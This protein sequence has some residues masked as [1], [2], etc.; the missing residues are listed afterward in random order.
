VLRYAWR[1]PQGLPPTLTVEWQLVSARWLAIVIVLLELLWLQ[2]SDREHTSALLIVGVGALYNLAVQQAVHRRSGLLAFGYVTA[3]GDTL[4]I[5]AMVELAGGFDSPFAS[6]FFV[7]CVSIAMRCGFGPALSMALLVIAAESIGRGA[8]PAPLA[9]RGVCLCLS[10]FFASHVR[11]Q[12]QRETMQNT[13]ILEQMTEAVL[14]TDAAGRIVLTNAAAQKLY[15]SPGKPLLGTSMAAPLVDVLG[16]RKLGVDLYE[17]AVRRALRG[18]PMEAEHQVFDASGNGQWLSASATPLRGIRGSIQGA[19]VVAHDLTERKL[20]L[21]ALRASEER[22]RNQYKGFP[23]PTYSWIRDGDDFFLQDFNDAAKAIDEA[24]V[25]EMLI[26]RASERYA[27]QPEILADLQECVAEQRTL[28][29]EMRYRFRRTGLERNV[30]VTYVFVPPQTVMAHIEDVTEA[31]Q[32]EQQREAMAQSEKLRAL[33]QMASGIAHDLNQSLMLVASYSDLARQALVQDPPNVAELE[34]LLTTTTQAALDGGETVK[35]LLQFTQAVPEHEG[36][37]VDLSSV[38]RDAAQLTAP[39][40]RDAAQAEGRPISLHVEVEGNPTIQGSPAR[41]RELMTNLIFNAVDALPT[42]GAIR[43]RVTA[44]DGQGIVEV[45]DSGIGMSAAVQERVFEPF[46]T[47][48]GEGGTGLGLA[49]VFGIVER[50]RGHIEVHSAPDDGT[51]F[52]M[53]FPLMADALAEALLTPSPRPSVQLEPP[54]PLRVLA[55]DDEPMMT[56]AVVRMLK[57]SGHL[58]SVAGS[59][60][61]A[62][63]KLAEQTFDVVVSDMGMGAGMNGWELAEAVR[64]RWPGVRFLLA[65]G[66]GAG[67]DPVEAR[68]KGIEA[69]LA[70]PYHP[71][72]LLEALGRT[73]VAA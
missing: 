27:G 60:E 26:V 67:M 70:K 72:E 7:L 25:G 10:V 56:K 39:R 4:L 69:V 58:V 38:V 5:L 20:V 53:T 37:L 48:K 30:V 57:P 2:L 43:L 11:G 41:L 31:K 18:E 33:G 29:R 19:I 52:R 44:E 68:T 45:I 14:V 3:L 62:L 23:L 49:M 61:E 35:R 65:T 73:D 64:S 15:G 21:E 13:A 50:H 40:W 32:A 22:F 6:V 8:A 59:G 24:D 36:K 34:D 47:T 46:F 28:R 12:G 9:I 54:R 16:E 71:A 17:L 42:G 1:G 66:W 63:E 55:V 51:T